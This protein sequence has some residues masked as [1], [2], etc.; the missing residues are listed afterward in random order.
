MH[1]FQRFNAVGVTVLVATHDIHL[2][3][4]FRVRRVH[5]EKGRLASVPHVAG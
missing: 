5:I 1:L 3:D 2:L 4:R